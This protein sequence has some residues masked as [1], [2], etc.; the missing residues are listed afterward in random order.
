MPQA[1]ISDN[2][3]R[4]NFLEPLHLE[5]RLQLIMADAKVLSFGS[6]LF[7]AISFKIVWKGRKE[8]T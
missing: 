7:S 8:K 5:R 3:A 4:A 1:F 2:M 6:T